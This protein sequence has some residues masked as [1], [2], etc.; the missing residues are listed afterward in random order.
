MTALGWIGR[1]VH[2]G[3]EVDRGDGD[4]IVSIV[5]ELKTSFVSFSRQIVA[6][7]RNKE[8]LGCDRV[9]TLACETTQGCPRHRVQETDLP[10]LPRN[11]PKLDNSKSRY[12]LFDR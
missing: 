3:S 10:L 1:P 9:P 11:V 7:S 8:D 12:H 5:P 6:I 2:F 4:G